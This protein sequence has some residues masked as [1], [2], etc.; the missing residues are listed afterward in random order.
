LIDCTDDR[1]GEGR[2]QQEDAGAQMA[3]QVPWCRRLLDTWPK[4][5]SR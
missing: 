2:P 1:M 4:G 5:R 3:S